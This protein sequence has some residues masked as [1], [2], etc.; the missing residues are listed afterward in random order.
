MLRFVVKTTK[1]DTLH[2]HLIQ[3]TMTKTQLSASLVRDERL[4]RFG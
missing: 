1:N 3:N 2:A 4:A